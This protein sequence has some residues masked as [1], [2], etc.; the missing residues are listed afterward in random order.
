MMLSVH[1]A[2]NIYIRRHPISHENS[3]SLSYEMAAWHVYAC[4][5]A[6]IQ[7]AAMFYFSCIVMVEV[8]IMNNQIWRGTIMKTLKVDMCV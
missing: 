2:E 5:P 4:M 3:M 8:D 1:L 7:Q 6:N